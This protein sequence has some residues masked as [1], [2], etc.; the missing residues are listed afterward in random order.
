MRNPDS[1]QQ[2]VEERTA[3]TSGPQAFSLRVTRDV[4]RLAAGFLTWDTLKSKDSFS[5]SLIGQQLKHFV[6]LL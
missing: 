2:L 4:A 5:L 1:L 3:G 6:Q